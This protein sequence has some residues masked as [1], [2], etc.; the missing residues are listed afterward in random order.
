MFNTSAA[1]VSD[2]V[3]QTVEAHS[4]N[5]AVLSREFA[6]EFGFGSLGYVAGLFH[7]VGKYGELFQRYIKSATGLID[8]SD[9]SYLDYESYRGKIDHSTAGAAVS[10]NFANEDNYQKLAME[11]VALAIM[12]HHTGLPDMIS[13]IPGGNTFDNRLE[14]CRSDTSYYNIERSTRDNIK[15][16]LTGNDLDDCGKILK[17]YVEKI[18]SS[19]AGEFRLGLLSR[20]LLSCLIDADRMDTELFMEGGHAKQYSKDADW[21][22]LIDKLV[23]YVA[24]LESKGKISEVRAAVL[25]SCISNSCRSRG[26][27]TLSVPT[28]GGKT[29]SSLRF[30]LEHAKHHKM[31]RI[32]YVVPY[33]SIIDQNAKVIRDALEDLNRGIVLEHHSSFAVGESDL[34]KYADMTDNWDVPIILTTMVQFLNTLFGSGTAT[35][36]RMHNL[37]NSVLIFDEIQ[38]LPIKCTSMFNEAVNYLVE[39]C[40]CT[41]VL[42]TATQPRLDKLDRH[43]IKLAEEPVLVPEKIFS[44]MPKRTVFEDRTRDEGWSQQDIARLAVESTD[45]GESTLVIM[46]TKADALAIAKQVEL[47]SGDVFYLSTYLCPRHRLKVI[48]DIRNR[49]A[50]GRRTICVSTQV[51]EAGV[52]LDFDKVIRSLAGWNSIIQ[53]AGRCNRNGKKAE[54]GKVFIVNSSSELIGS[55]P[56]IRIGQDVSRRILNHGLHE[57][58]SDGTISTFMKWYNKDM[59]DLNTFIFEYPLRDY[60]TNMYAM[61]SRNEKFNGKRIARYMKQSFRTANYEFN[62]LE[63]DSV[64]VIIHEMDDEG[65]TGRIKAAMEE[66]LHCPRDLMRAAQRISV[67]VRLGVLKNMIKGNIASE[68]VPDSGVYICKGAYDSKFGLVKLGD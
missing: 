10:L 21:S 60:D 8:R 44:D 14:K 57:N 15:S 59:K 58:D 3:V 67:N 37:V 40:G 26:T 62:A 39:D 30:A 24:T 66:Y 12:S 33:M 36:R 7:D 38:A 56:E 32:V 19:N 2:N 45:S 54:P 18:R 29:L 64:G 46:N 9:V 63:D 28:G 20:N 27:Y 50:T 4:K 1:H 34:E 61:L 5:V 51:I 68:L 22:I 42:C 16:M 43:G 47:L 41:A 17:E 25:N 31:R 52:D 49:L 13:P 6:N 48:S 55:I 65:L 23:G 53:A 35:V 11:I